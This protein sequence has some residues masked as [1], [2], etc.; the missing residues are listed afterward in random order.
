MHGLEWLDGHRAPVNSWGLGDPTYYAVI[1]G[2]GIRAWTCQRWGRYIRRDTGP[3][4]QGIY[5]LVL[6]AG[7]SCI[8]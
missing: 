3:F 6:T 8:T 5:L 1:P 7:C 4:I 2:A